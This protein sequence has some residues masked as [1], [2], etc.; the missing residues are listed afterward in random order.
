MNPYRDTLSSLIQRRDQLLRELEELDQHIES[1]AY[2][3]IPCY[4]GLSGLQRLRVRRAWKL[5][6]KLGPWQEK[7]CEM[8]TW[9]PC[10]ERHAGRSCGFVDEL[11]KPKRDLYPSQTKLKNSD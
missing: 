1:R 4:R 7:C 9:D 8:E 5:I 3:L 11:V 10:P 2:Q 6:A